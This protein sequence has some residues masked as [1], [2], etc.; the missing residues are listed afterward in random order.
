MRSKRSAT[1]L[2]V[3]AVALLACGQPASAATPAPYTFTKVFNPGSGNQQGL[4]YAAGSY[5]VG[6]DGG[7]GKVDHLI[8]YDA[9]GKVK[10]D[11]AGLDLGHAAE[12]AFRNADG[13]LYVASGGGD[14]PTYVRVVDMSKTTPTV[15]KTYD[16]T[17][18]GEDGMV[19]VDNANDQMV[20]FAGTSGGTHTVALADF[21]TGTIKSHFT[22]PALGTPNGIEVLGSTIL[23]LTTYNKKC[24]VIT[25]FS[26]TGQPQYS[27]PLTLPGEGEGLAADNTTG[28]LYVGER[29]PNSVYKIAPAWAGP[30]G[31]NVL[32]NGDAECGDA[33]ATNGSVTS[34]PGWVNAG[35]DSAKMSTIAYGGASYPSASSPGPTDRGNAFFSGGQDNT[36]TLTQE[37]PLAG[38]SQD[39]AAGLRYN[40][41]G[42]LGGYKAQTDTAK[43]VVT[44]KSS[45]GA[46][47]G[48]AQIGPVTH[49]DRNDVTGLLQRT[50]T[51]TV[52]A[53]TQ[54][55]SVVVTASKDTGTNNDGYSDSLSLVFTRA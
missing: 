9:S 18:L 44:F 23:Y 46:T 2:A 11:A 35:T 8:Q 1:V 50:A 28:D 43:V 16:F 13:K 15:E 34:I 31:N 40:L 48:T 53:G 55:A 27:V 37:V 47:V 36:A 17:A 19:A 6:F 20:V 4:A 5:Y 51:G 7:T 32:T 41:N 42:W 22:V 38:V 30:L 54:S 3:G 12:V 10:K 21:A 25:A 29:P 45:T 49:T 26:L 33:G 24:N 39:V 52:P 14:Q